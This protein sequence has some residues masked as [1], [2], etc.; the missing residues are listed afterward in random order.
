MRRTRRAQAK[1]KAFSDTKVKCP[2]DPE[3]TLQYYG[4]PDMVAFIRDAKP[5]RFWCPKCGS[6]Y[7]AI[8]K[9]GITEEETDRRVKEV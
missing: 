3:V 7:D 6:K 4:K 5:V 1:S 8:I 2:K 9:P